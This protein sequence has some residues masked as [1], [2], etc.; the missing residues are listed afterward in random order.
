MA[1]RGAPR[2]RDRIFPPSGGVTF[3][4]I[5]MKKRAT[6]SVLSPLRAL[7]C[8]PNYPL[9]NTRRLARARARDVLLRSNGSVRAYIACTVKYRTRPLRLPGLPAD[10]EL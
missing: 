6:P 5:A 2:T 10:D 1:E 7:I 9:A 4:R 3:H 8:M